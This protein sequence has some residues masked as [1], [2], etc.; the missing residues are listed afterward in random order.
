M[1]YL[2]TFYIFFQIIDAFSQYR[3]VKLLFSSTNKCHPMVCKH[4]NYISRNFFT[5]PSVLKY[6]EF[7]FQKNNFCT[8]LFCI[9][10][11]L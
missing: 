11:Y 7:Y 10:I 1:K 4:F 5:F 3:V 6:R 9:Y 2:I 8:S